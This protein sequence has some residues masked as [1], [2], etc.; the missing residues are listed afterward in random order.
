M[1]DVRWMR[2]RC[3]VSLRVYG[4]VLKDFAGNSWVLASEENGCGTEREK[5]TAMETD[6]SGAAPPSEIE[7]MM[8]KHSW[9]LSS[10]CVL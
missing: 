9:E 3:D 6:T 8:T 2:S 4:R 10:H 1:M 7:M 5:K